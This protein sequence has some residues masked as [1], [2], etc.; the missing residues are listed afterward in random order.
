MPQPKL[1]I[2]GGENTLSKRKT[3][4]QPYASVQPPA[5]PP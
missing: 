3:A 4:G 5:V 1:I 2:Q